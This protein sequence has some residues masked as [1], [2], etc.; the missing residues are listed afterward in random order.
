MYSVY[1]KRDSSST[2]G[3]FYIGCSGGETLNMSGSTNG[4]PYFTAFGISGLPQGVWCLVVGILHANNHPS[5][6]NSGKGGVW[7]LDTGQKLRGTTDF[8]MRY[9]GTRNQ[10]HRTYLYYSTDPA[11]HLKWWGPGVHEINGNE[12]NICL[13]YTSPSPRD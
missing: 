3:T 9:T 5:T 8:K 12:P 13:L 4:N 11:A 1:V 10:T 7:R 2:N 6:S